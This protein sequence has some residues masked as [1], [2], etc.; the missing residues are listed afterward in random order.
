MTPVVLLIA[1]PST[2]QR[3][4]AAGTVG[5]HCSNP[6]AEVGARQFNPGPLCQS[7]ITEINQSIRDASLPAQ[8]KLVGPERLERVPWT[9]DQAEWGPGM[10]VLWVMCGQPKTPSQSGGNGGVVVVGAQRRMSLDSSFKLGLAVQTRGTGD[11]SGLPAAL[12]ALSMQYNCQMM[13]ETVN[14]FLIR[15]CAGHRSFIG[16]G[17]RLGR[18]V[19]GTGFEFSLSNR[20]WSCRVT[21]GDPHNCSR[22]REGARSSVSFAVGQLEWRPERSSRNKWPDR[23]VSGAYCRSLTGQAGNRLSGVSGLVFLL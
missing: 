13:A 11:W 2:P 5:S 7:F 22:E 4:S 9:V 15:Q 6:G 14:V 19:R 8:V 21:K 23:W 16:L 10:L 17:H 12:A 1:A 3:R 20:H 18:A